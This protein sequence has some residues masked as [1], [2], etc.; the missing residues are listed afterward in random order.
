MK[1]I[2]AKILSL[3][4]CSVIILSLISVKVAPIGGLPP[5][6]DV[7]LL[8][9][10]ADISPGNPATV[11]VTYTN[12]GDTDYELELYVYDNGSLFDSPRPQFRYNGKT[13]TTTP[14]QRRIFESFY[15][16]VG[17]SKTVTLIFTVTSDMENGTY[18]LH[19]GGQIL[20]QSNVVNFDEK[21]FWLN[22]T[23]G[24]PPPTETPKES[25][26][27]R[28]DVLSSTG[29][30]QGEFEEGDSVIFD[31]SK[32]YDP[33]GGSLTF[34]WTSNI[35]GFLSNQSYFITQTLSIGEHIIMLTVTDD[36]GDTD[37]ATA[38]I[39]IKEENL[40]P[41][42]DAGPDLTVNV[43]EVF[44]LDASNSYDP[45]GT[46][47]SYS[48]IFGP[49]P[50]SVKG[51]KAVTHSYSAAGEYT[52]TLSVTD[53]D[54]AKSEDTIVITV[55]GIEPQISILTDTIPNTLTIGKEYEFTI[56]VKAE[57]G[58]IENLQATL[59]TDPAHIEVLTDTTI[60]CGNL[61]SDD[62]FVFSWKVSPTEKG[63]IEI[64]IVFTGDNI[65]EKKIKRSVVIS[66]QE[67]QDLAN[68]TQRDPQFELVKV[69]IIDD[70]PAHESDSLLRY[71]EIRY[72]LTTEFLQKTN[73]F[74]LSFHGD[75]KSDWKVKVIKI[76]G[77]KDSPAENI[78]WIATPA[79]EI[80]GLSGS[81]EFDF[82]IER[83][84]I[85]IVVVQRS[86]D[87]LGDGTYNIYFQDDYEE[88]DF[89]KNIEDMANQF[90]GQ[91]A[92]NIAFAA[93]LYEF[94]NKNLPAI[95]QG[96]I[97]QT[98]PA[99]KVTI[100]SAS[101]YVGAEGSVNIGVGGEII[102]SIKIIRDFDG[103]FYVALQGREELWGKIGT[104]VGVSLKGGIKVRSGPL[105]MN[106]GGGGELSAGV[107]ALLS[108]NCQITYYQDISTV[109]NALGLLSQYQKINPSTVISYLIIEDICGYQIP[110][111]YD[112]FLVYLN[113]GIL[114]P[115]ASRFF[116]EQSQF[117][118]SS[119]FQYVQDIQDFFTSL[120]KTWREDNTFIEVRG[121]PQVPSRIKVSG[122]VSGSVPLSVIFAG[123][124]LLEIFMVT[125][126]ADL[127]LLEVEAYP[128]IRFYTKPRVTVGVDFKADFT[129]LRINLLVTNTDLFN[130]VFQPEL[131]IEITSS[132]EN[133]D[134]SQEVTVKR[135]VAPD[136]YCQDT[137]INQNL[138]RDLISL[139][140]TGSL[141]D[142]T[143]QE[144]LFKS[145]LTVDLQ[146]TKQLITETE[147]FLDTSIF[148]EI[149][150]GIV[151][152]PDISV[153]IGARSSVKRMISEP[154]G[155]N[156][157]DLYDGSLKE[158]SENDFAIA[159]QYLPR[160]FAPDDLSLVPNTVYYRI[161]FNERTGEAAIQY[162][163]NPGTIMCIR[164]YVYFDDID[165]L[166]NLSS[167]GWPIPSRFVIFSNFLSMDGQ[168][169]ITIIGNPSEIYNIL[170]RSY[171]DNKGDIQ[172][173][174]GDLTR[175]IERNYQLSTMNGVTI[176]N[177]K[178]VKRYNIHYFKTPVDKESITLLN[179]L[180]PDVL[181]ILNK[182]K[183]SQAEVFEK[184]FSHSSLRIPFGMDDT[185]FSWTQEGVFL[186]TNFNTDVANFRNP[187]LNLPAS[188]DT[189]FFVSTHC[190]VEL[191]VY[192]SQGRHTGFNEQTA[193][194]D[195]EIPHSHYYK[196]GE[197]TYVTIYNA[198]DTYKIE[199]VG[200]DDGMYNLTVSQPVE[201]IVAG[202]TSTTRVTVPTEVHMKKNEVHSVSYDSKDLSEKI[203]EKTSEII[204]DRGLQQGETQLDDILDEAA[205][206]VV[207]SI[208]TDGDGVPDVEDSTPIFVKRKIPIYWL[209]IVGVV[210][211][212]I[213]SYIGR[214]TLKKAVTRIELP[215]ISGKKTEAKITVNGKSYNLTGSPLTVGRCKDADIRID[216]PD[217]VVSRVH[218]KIF[219]D[220]GQ[221]WIE[222]MNSRHGTF[223]YQ[224]NQY[225]KIQK[226]ALYDGD[227]I[228]LCYDPKKG[229]GLPLMF[230]TVKNGKPVKT[231][232]AGKEA[233]VIVG[234]KR[235]PLT[236]KI[237]TIGR[238][239]KAD[240][241]I[242]DPY[243]LVSRMH[244][245]ILKDDSGQYWVEDTNSKHGTFVYQNGQ[246]KK[247][248]K[249]ALYDGD[250][251]VLC[252]DVEGGKEFPI[253]FRKQ[254]NDMEV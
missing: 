151:I 91:F 23:G 110:H 248:L 157:S 152:D 122:E 74:V 243:Q 53:D 55:I 211:L 124:P 240:I 64:E 43:N 158:F 246:Y 40:P 101:L 123:I 144:A 90:G 140:S 22:M 239:D 171:F 52:V 8:P 180:T 146:H 87:L 1:K 137:I 68:K 18:K 203:S 169:N 139:F 46:I 57:N 7:F 147:V 174:H 161:L 113:L 175:F 65:S 89:D 223:V 138:A 233:E 54:K 234:G 201:V 125:S 209:I 226:W 5:Q 82:T 31:G 193:T 189:A 92:Q 28:I 107:D 126:G 219:K 134:I 30:L 20:D 162:I 145:I 184:E 133:L 177:K 142:Q 155:F 49:Y 252:H 25:P 221:Y 67:Y 238:S 176:E 97:E 106:F 166:K 217:Q 77:N 118:V 48:W 214:K 224:N 24:V 69:V 242:D 75:G 109:M 70:Y 250:V 39:T 81:Y 210:M 199:V 170:A 117:F 251:I 131:G 119:I 94:L 129:D 95:I 98:F 229:K 194:I 111:I 244:S 153:D 29:E 164:F 136:V 204:K 168:G 84:S 254:K 188:M 9:T 12:I 165:D 148:F 212:C 99:G 62:E 78:Q 183:T 187:F 51:G 19:I 143:L 56:K 156:Q 253:K 150:G 66:I 241:R 127:T 213:G 216:D 208:D 104:G 21:A 47:V 38:Q 114:D 130:D 236:K 50:Y 26:R 195:V 181:V 120:E 190:P 37:T 196:V 218:A 60:R 185:Y 173:I 121:I 85:V 192:D 36:E 115:Q 207:M 93:E 59:R 198:N 105:E 237:M 200:T 225:K 112:V 63:S 191:H 249:W 232:I 186:A 83:P 44:T 2:H 11:E 182:A 42:A 230:G 178:D 116:E 96:R 45:D 13:F 163:I 227:V 202:S 141:Y 100:A 159:S 16:Q 197:D 88:S 220:S 235:I 79:K 14:D 17:E 245:Q 71:K 27:A 34:S 160:I 215:T 179:K 61:Y 73:R 172:K 35:D 135:K 222:D 206:E 228:V 154:W 58:T 3:F 167:G 86:G 149:K 41:V 103:T 72:V 80:T 15:L 10:N 247:I 132:I 102:G 32:S 108:Q 6:V 33:D 231:K 205:E 76:F 4:Y 128:Y